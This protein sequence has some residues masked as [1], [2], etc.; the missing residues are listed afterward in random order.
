MAASVQAEILFTGTAD[1]K[2][3]ADVMRR[4]RAEL[5]DQGMRYFRQD[6]R[7]PNQSDDRLAQK[8]IMFEDDIS[9]YLM[10][11]EP[12]FSEREQYHF[13]TVL[14]GSDLDENEVELEWSRLCDRLDQMTNAVV[15]SAVI[16][17]A[18]PT[19]QEKTPRSRSLA[20]GEPPLELSI[21]C[22]LSGK[23]LDQIT[24]DALGLVKSAKITRS[25]QGAFI[26]LGKRPGEPFE[27]VEG[28]LKNNPIFRLFDPMLDRSS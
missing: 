6:D 16:A 12:R 15:P 10:M 4:L 22:Y 23:I 13:V 7:D 21:W 1:E 14:S 26:Q 25:D 24:M 8:A 18:T 3:M 11:L 19:G 2:I 27:G 9:P 5:L 20:L 17:W 28:Y